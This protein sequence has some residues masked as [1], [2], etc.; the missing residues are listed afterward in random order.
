[1]GGRNPPAQSD[2]L[3]WE[4]KDLAE[5]GTHP[6]QSG[7]EKVAKMLLNFFEKDANTKTW[8]VRP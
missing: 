6:S 8:F 1:M 5:D 7:R 4:R 2:G 3:T